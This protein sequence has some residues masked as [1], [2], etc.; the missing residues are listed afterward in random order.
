MAIVKQAK[1]QKAR[2]FLSCGYAREHPRRCGVRKAVVLV[3]S[4][5]EDF[6]SVDDASVYAPKRGRVHANVAV[7]LCSLEC[8]AFQTQSNMQQR[9][10]DYVVAQNLRLHRGDEAKGRRTHSMRTGR[11]P[12]LESHWSTALLFAGVVSVCRTTL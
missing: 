9:G 6:A 1:K 12:R 2:R 7:C 8:L 5:H 3:E 10:I 4:K 11:L